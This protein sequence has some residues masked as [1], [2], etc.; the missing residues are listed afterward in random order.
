MPEFAGSTAR[1]AIAL[2]AGLLAAGCDPASGLA[3]PPG[4]SVEV[5]AVEVAQAFA[6]KDD[7]RFTRYGPGA[8]PYRVSGTVRS[9]EQLEDGS[10]R[11]VLE[12]GAGNP[13][14]VLGGISM[15]RSL[16]R[17]IAAGDEASAFCEGVYL[18][19]AELVLESRCW[20]DR[21]FYAG[22]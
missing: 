14:V 8:M 10:Y 17:G 21:D 2:M 11:I 18:G 13:R 4:S 3:P 12:S 20:L 22:R 5:T 1:R 19:D 16:A 15:G 7:S 9:I 6:A